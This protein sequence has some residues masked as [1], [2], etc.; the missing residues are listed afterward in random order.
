MSKPPKKG[1]KKAPSVKAADGPNW[2]EVKNVEAIIAGFMENPAAFAARESEASV[3]KESKTLKSGAMIN[4][5]HSVV[6]GVEGYRVG[7]VIGK[8]A[9]TRSGLK[10]VPDEAKDPYV[11]AVFRD[12]AHVAVMWFGPEE[13]M[14]RIYGSLSREG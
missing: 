1:Q 11:L 14:R 10:K 9:A 3:I 12:A 8:E 5:A 13:E 7:W 6:G 4:L 2:R